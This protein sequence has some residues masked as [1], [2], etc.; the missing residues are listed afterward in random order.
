M[1]TWDIE[2]GMQ[3]HELKK[4]HQYRMILPNG[5]SYSYLYEL[6]AGVLWN[7]GKNKQS[8]WKFHSGVRFKLMR[9]KKRKNYNSISFDVEFKP[10]SIRVGCQEI[11]ASDALLLSMD[12]WEHF[13]SE[14]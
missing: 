1:G 2:D 11:K 6:K 10:K 7:I 4:D 12:I 14:E 8:T 9:K 3:F 5:H 13:S